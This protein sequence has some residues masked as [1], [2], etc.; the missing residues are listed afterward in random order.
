MHQ[1]KKGQ[2]WYFGMKMHVGVDSKSKVI[3]SVVATP[4]NTADGK[5]LGELLHGD[6]TRVYGDQAYKSQ[7]Q[8]IRAKAPR[9]KDFTNPS[10]QVEALHRPGD[11]GQEP[12][13]V[14]HT[15]SRRPGLVR[16]HTTSFS[17]MITDRQIAQPG[18]A[19]ARYSS[20]H[21]RRFL[22]HSSNQRR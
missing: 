16:R 17:T 1:A 11:Q 20:S 10:V 14:A 13:Q 5:V 15:R 21:C 12:E 9:A 3:H 7:E 22:R 6:E 2:Q 8:V 4:A 19:Y 18:D